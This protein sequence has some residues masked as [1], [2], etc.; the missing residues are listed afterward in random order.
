[1]CV[2]WW[3][4]AIRYYESHEFVRDHCLWSYEYCIEKNLNSIPKNQLYSKKT[5]KAADYTTIIVFQL[6]SFLSTFSE[7]HGMR[8]E[9]FFPKNNEK[10]PIS[11]SFS[12]EI[13]LGW[14][15]SKKEYSTSHS[16]QCYKSKCRLLKA[17]LPFN[18]LLCPFSYPCG[19]TSNKMDTTTLVYNSRTF[20][21][22]ITR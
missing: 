1:M 4:G 8:N 14:K 22:L 15:L 5:R 16:T 21:R 7:F 2:M 11:L 12:E 6:F 10:L 19:Q 17:V 20:P 18:L 9:H 3:S 13:G